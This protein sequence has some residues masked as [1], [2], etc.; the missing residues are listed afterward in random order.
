MFERFKPTDEDLAQ[1]EARY[2]L[3]GRYHHRRIVR[4]IESVIDRSEAARARFLSECLR[5]Q[6]MPRPQ[7][8][9][10][11]LW[12]SAR[13]LAQSAAISLMIRLLKVKH[14]L[15]IRY[16]PWFDRDVGRVMD[17]KDW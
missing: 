9:A 13:L 16:A 12:W 3:S 2:R 1:I 6:T 8:W 5:I 4:Q 17:H 7:R 11:W 10:A 15:W 14:S